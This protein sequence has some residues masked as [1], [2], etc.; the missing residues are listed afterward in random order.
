MNKSSIFFICNWCGH[1]TKE[2][3]QSKLY[4]L[5]CANNCYKE[6]SRCRRPFNDK[7]YFAISDIRCNSCQRKYLK[8]ITK[9][10]LYY[11][12]NNNI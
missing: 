4:C 3:Y 5:K 2:L 10:H 11:S 7:K 12:N 1:L 8:E 6:C 9:R